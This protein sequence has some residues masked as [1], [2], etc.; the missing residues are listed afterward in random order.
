[1]IAAAQ[2][3]PNTLTAVLVMSSKRSTTNTIPTPIAMVASGNP[4]ACKITIIA[5]KLAEGIPATPIDVSKAIMTTVDCVTQSISIPKSCARKTTTTHSNKAVP[6]I[7]IVAPRGKVK[8]AIFL[9]TPARF[10]I[11]LRVRGK[12]AEEDAVENAV[13]KAGDTAWKCFV[14]LILAKK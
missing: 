12:V 9:E 5:T 8:L 6:S 10:V 14:K 13:S 7:F 4:T 1:M 2:L 11:Q 3:S